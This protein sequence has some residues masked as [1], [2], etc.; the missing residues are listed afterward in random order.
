MLHVRVLIDKYDHHKTNYYSMHDQITYFHSQRVPMTPELQTLSCLS[1]FPQ[2][3]HVYL[4][5]IL[6]HTQGQIHSLTLI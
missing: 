4:I 3:Q 2:Q 5:R 6:A 1:L